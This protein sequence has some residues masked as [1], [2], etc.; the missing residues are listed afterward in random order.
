MIIFSTTT[1][2]NDFFKKALKH[3]FVLLF[4]TF[5]NLGANAQ[6]PPCSAPVCGTNGCNEISI[7]Y[8]VTVPDGVCDSTNV[9]FVNFGSDC[10]DG[11]PSQFSPNATLVAGSVG[12]ADRVYTVT[13]I[14]DRAAATDAAITFVAGGTPDP[15]T[16]FCFGGAK[17]VTIGPNDSYGKVTYVHGSDNAS[18]AYTTV[19]PPAD[20]DLEINIDFPADLTCAGGGTVT[21]QPIID[22]GMNSWCEGTTQTPTIPSYSY[23]SSTGGTY[24]TTIDL[25]QPC[26]IGDVDFTVAVTSD[27][28]TTTMTCAANDP[29][30]I[31]IAAGE[32]SGSVTVEFMDL[33]AAPVELTTFNATANRDKN[34]LLLWETASELNNE[35]FQVEYSTDGRNF[36]SLG[37]VNGRGTTSSVSSYRFVHDQ[38]VSK[39]NY[40]RLKQ[41]DFDGKFEYSN[42][43]VAKLE[44][45]K[46]L[47]IVPTIVK[48]ALQVHYQGEESEVVIFNLNGQIVYQA[49]KNF[50]NGFQEIGVNDLPKGIY[51]LSVVDQ[52]NS[53]L[54]SARFIKQ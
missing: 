47:T 16:A 46:S 7:E 31:T 4:L 27:D 32:T 15:N 5:L 23:D 35:Y 45:D 10:A 22:F 6:G 12:G 25:V 34:V 52:K 3:S 44:I 40:Y 36:T 13:V 26:A 49:V 48:D 50:E 29:E 24:T 38:P 8:E 21:V 18:T 20:F 43:A 19:T 53:Y 51:F 28:G 1:Y 17:S 39:L 30:T 54:Q 14:H 2:Q 9:F 37:T 42:V 33:A 11:E 41:V